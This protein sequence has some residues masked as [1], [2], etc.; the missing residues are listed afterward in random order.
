MS[1]F[2][3]H[4]CFI[5]CINVWFSLWLI[6]IEG[7]VGPIK[8]YGQPRKIK[9]LLKKH[10]K[11]SLK[12][13]HRFDISVDNKIDI[14]IESLWQKHWYFNLKISWY[15]ILKKHWNLGYEKWW[16]LSQYEL[17][18][19]PKKMLIKMMKWCYMDACFDAYFNTSILMIL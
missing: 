10:Q 9:P 1:L 7:S 3:H 12:F 13:L 14:S 11:T 19:R 17:Q 8:G 18:K 16:Y 15:F 5:L 4:I 6:K 2:S